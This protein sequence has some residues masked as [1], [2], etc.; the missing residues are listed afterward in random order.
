MS[1]LGVI[2]R[3]VSVTFPILDAPT[4]MLT[5]WITGARAAAP[6]RSVTALHDLSVDLAAGDRVGLIGHNGAG[7][8]TFLRT[9]AGI[10]AP[11]R[12]EVVVRG[13]VRCL[14]QIAA[15]MNQT[16]TGYQNIPLLA[17]ANRIPHTALPE[18]TRS[19]EVFTE[20]GDALDRPVR[21]YSSGM[22]LRLAFAVATANR[23]DVLLMDEVVGVGDRDFR[24]KARERIEE[25]MRGAG[26][27]VLASHSDA[28]LKSYCNRGLVLSKGRI[29]FDG[30]IDEAL[31]AA[32]APS[33]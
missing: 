20:L 5:G 6:P 7:K 32:Q 21:T 11:A 33:R 2:F 3:S 19:V 28:H 24:T 4:R 14:F 26:I 25:M 16:A 9:I 27:L 18:L 31:E 23:S 12:G 10:Y 8:S 17:A 13:G 1:D 29:A 22:R 15:G 30:P